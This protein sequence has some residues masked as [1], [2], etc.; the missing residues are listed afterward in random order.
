MQNLIFVMNKLLTIISFV[1]IFGMPSYA[2]QYNKNQQPQI[3][4]KPKLVVGIVVDQM[5]FDYLSRFNSKFGSVVLSAYKTKALIVRIIILI[6]YQHIQG[7]AM[8]PFL[9]E[10][11]QSITV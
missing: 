3:N 10:L 2:F 5:R 9:L 8:H 11:H 4:T 6:I 1:F 7:L